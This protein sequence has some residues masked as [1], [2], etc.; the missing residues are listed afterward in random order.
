V[1]LIDWVWTFRLCFND[2]EER[3]SNPKKKKKKINII[4][5]LFGTS[6]EILLFRQIASLV[7]VSIKWR[8]R[9]NIHDSEIKFLGTGSDKKQDRDKLSS[10]SSRNF[11]I[12]YT[13]G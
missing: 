2:E 5:S 6:H 13:L 8:K 12:K 4:P 9:T 3:I 1:R 7:L 10:E 11:T